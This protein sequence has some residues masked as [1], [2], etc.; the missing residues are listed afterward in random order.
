[1]SVFYPVGLSCS[2]GERIDADLCVSVNADRRPDLR[3]E[4]LAGRFQ[5]VPCPACGAAIRLE[6]ELTYIDLAHGLWILAKP[7]SDIA[8]WRVMEEEARAIFER[9]YGARAPRPARA[10]GARLDP[11]VVFGWAALREKIACA[12]A[13][14][15]DLA[16]ELVK[17]SLLRAPGT[18]LPDGSSDWRL[19]GADDRLLTFGLVEADTD[20]VRQSIQAPRAALG[21][22]LD[23]N[24]WAAPRRALLGGCFVDVERLLTEPA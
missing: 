1:M 13:G 5:V 16:V 4:I 14:V 22:V 19:I 18:S 10:L 2:C 7:R 3:D 15:D 6:P 12:L 11:R 9:T 21:P 20:A 8:Q 17:T 24:A 23:A